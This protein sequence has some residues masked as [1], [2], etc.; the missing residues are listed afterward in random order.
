MEYWRA[1]EPLGKLH[2]LV[3]YTQRS[4]Q[5]IARFRE[6]SGGRNLVRDNATRWN[7]WYNMTKRGVELKHALGLFCMQFQEDLTD[8]LSP[9]D[10]KDLKSY[11]ASYYVSTMLHS[12]LNLEGL[13]LSGF[14]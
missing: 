7:S 10:W 6:L 2:N 9:E 8:M 1:K 11:R 3:V 5:Q 12:Q 4:P 13:L 14:F